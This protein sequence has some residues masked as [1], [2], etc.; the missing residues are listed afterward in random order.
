MCIN[1]PGYSVVFLRL[2]FCMFGFE[3]KCLLFLICFAKFNFD[4]F[5]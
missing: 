1:F 2:I 4:D 5:A 3:P